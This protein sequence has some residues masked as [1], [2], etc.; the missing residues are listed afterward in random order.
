MEPS[1][2]LPNSARST[3]SHCSNAHQKLRGFKSGTTIVNASW[4]SCSKRY[5]KRGRGIRINGR[6]MKMLWSKGRE[7]A[8]TLIPLDSGVA[9]GVKWGKCRPTLLRWQLLPK[10]MR[11]NVWSP[12]RCSTWSQ[13]LFDNMQSVPDRLREGRSAGFLPV[14]T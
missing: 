2:L 6:N 8:R 13:A 4:K 9:Q 12:K 1:F 7:W 11:S 10:D 3:A 14:G 5:L